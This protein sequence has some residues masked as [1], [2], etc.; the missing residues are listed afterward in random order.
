MS[1]IKE[2][3]IALL[4]HHYPNAYDI[5][6]TDMGVY[7]YI[8]WEEFTISNSGNDTHVIRD[9]FIRIRCNESYRVQGLDGAR[10]TI[11]LKEIQSLY[12]HSHCASTRAGEF[13]KMC[14]GNTILTDLMVMLSSSEFC[15]ELFEMFLVQLDLYVR[16][17][18]L[19]GGPYKRISNIN[20][21]S[22][23]D[24]TL[25]NINSRALFQS[26]IG[27]EVLNIIAPFIK[28][29]EIDSKF[30]RTY[31]IEF[32]TK[33]ERIL[34]VLFESNPALGG[35]L[36][37]PDAYPLLEIKNEDTEEYFEYSPNL[38]SYLTRKT[39]YLKKKEEFNSR[40]SFLNFRGEAIY[41]KILEEGWERPFEEVEEQRA[42]GVEVLNFNITN[43]LIIELNKQISQFIKIK[44]YESYRD[45]VNTTAENSAITS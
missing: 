31:Q 22:T 11:S 18:S 23:S 35:I 17:E 43:S 39:E 26:P 12:M 9:F 44:L 21:T 14:T 7:I 36:G 1:T 37:I 41:I 10:A 2:N 28:L 8:K 27:K 15:M 24:L 13:Q 20:Y 6:E 25:N 4:E 42:N 38:T 19:E 40:G 3:I 32:N 30:G 33:V 34:G 16:W 45:K 5:Q 29:E